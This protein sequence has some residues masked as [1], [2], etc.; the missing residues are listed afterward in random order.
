MVGASD[1]NEGVKLEA[2]GAFE[3]GEHGVK[4]NVIL[5]GAVTRMAEGIDTSQFP[6]MDPARVA[7]MVRAVPARRL[8]KLPVRA[9]RLDQPLG[10]GPRPRSRRLH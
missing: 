8:P 4:S 9:R 3:G 6:P 2:D 7:P 5:P 1:V 10:V